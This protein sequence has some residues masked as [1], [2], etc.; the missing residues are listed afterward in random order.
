MSKRPLIDILPSYAG[1]DPVFPLKQAREGDAGADVYAT[2]DALIP[3]GGRILMGTG[4]RVALPAP[5]IENGGILLEEGIVMDVRPKSG[6]ALKMGLTLLNTPGTIDSG[7]RGEIAVILYNSN[8]LVDIDLLDS[9]VGAIDGSVDPARLKASVA[10]RREAAVI[11]IVRG[12]KIAQVVC[13]RYLVPDF[14][15]ADSPEELAETARGVGGFGST[16][17]GVPV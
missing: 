6:L 9:L 1:P 17:T 4:L 5:S 11:R 10:A 7:Y 16:G 8:P 3:P 15:V 13:M 12:Q 2:E 14:R